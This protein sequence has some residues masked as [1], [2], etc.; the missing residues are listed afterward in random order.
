[1]YNGWP[2]VDNDCDNG[3]STKQTVHSVHA[4]CAIVS[5]GVFIIFSFLQEMADKSKAQDSS[6]KVGKKWR[7]AADEWSGPV[8]K[9]GEKDEHFLHATGKNISF[10]G[11]PLKCTYIYVPF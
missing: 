11:Y 8:G 2:N 6:G 7:R 5:I 10:L 1:M 9:T 3:T 4:V